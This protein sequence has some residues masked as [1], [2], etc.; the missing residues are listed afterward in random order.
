MNANNRLSRRAYRKYIHFSDK[1]SI[2][3]E[4]FAISKFKSRIR[5]QLKFN[6]NSKLVTSAY[7][8][9]TIPFLAADFSA[10]LFSEKS[11]LALVPGAYMWTYPVQKGRGKK[12]DKRG[13]KKRNTRLS[14][15]LVGTANALVAFTNATISPGEGGSCSQSRVPTVCPRF[16]QLPYFVSLYIRCRGKRF[17]SFEN[18]ANA[19]DAS[20]RQSRA[21]FVLYLR[22]LA[23]PLRG[24][25]PSPLCFPNTGPE[26]TGVTWNSSSF[27]SSNDRYIDSRLSRAEIFP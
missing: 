7:T 18:F 25:N 15:N 11:K 13:E 2:I 12:R 17:P 1:G 24:S 10:T 3:R 22:Y 8:C 23:T 5:I 27:N 26:I 21:T 14:A 16:K 4:S 20:R 6:L 19:P 9:T